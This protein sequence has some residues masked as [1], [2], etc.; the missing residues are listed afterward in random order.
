MKSQKSSVTLT[1]HT[2]VEDLGSE[3]ARVTVIVESP[4]LKRYGLTTALTRNQMQYYKPGA[5]DRLVVNRSQ[6]QVLIAWV[7]EN[8]EGESNVDGN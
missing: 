6:R 7:C 2:E 8:L 5:L 1:L 4:G 3:G